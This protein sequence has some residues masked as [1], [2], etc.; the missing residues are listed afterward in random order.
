M[1]TSQIQK[2]NSVPSEMNS[3]QI[4]KEELTPELKEKV[5]LFA[6]SELI[7]ILVDESSLSK[8]E[9]ADFMNLFRLQ[10]R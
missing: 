1:D 9:G 2:V 10:A 6:T 5:E 7:K 4:Q 3:S 8:D